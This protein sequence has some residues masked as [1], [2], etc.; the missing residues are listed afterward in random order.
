[1]KKDYLKRLLWIAVPIMV[2]NLIA[3]LQM[4]IDRIFL[5]RLDAG[6]MTVLGNVTSPMWTTMSFCFSIVT[7]ASILI[8]QGVG[9]G[10]HDKSEEY[11]SSLI[12]YNNIIPFLL[13]L[14]WTFCSGYVF[15]F[16]GVDEAFV[17]FCLEYTRF[18]A[19][20]F[21]ITGI[22]AS[23]NVILQTSNYTK[24]L[25]VY[26]VVRSGLNILLDWILIF[27]R[28]GLPAMGIKGAA[29]ATTLA[30]YTG[31]IFVFIVI[32]NSKKLPTRPSFKS[33]LKAKFPSYLKGVRLGINTAFEDF[34][35][36]FGNL[37]LIRILN[38]IDP[39][40]AGIYSIVFS[41]EILV[42]V[43]IGSIGNGTMTLTSE[44]TGKKDLK[45]YK[46]VCGIAYSIC[47]AVAIVMLVLF[48][49]IP[50]QIIAIFT[51][52]QSIIATSSIYLAFIGINLFAKSANI[53]VGNSIRGSGNTQWM[54]YTQIFG[55]V[56]V[57]AIA[58]LFVY[59]FHLG[60]AGVFLAV[61]VDEA[62]R[63]LINFAKFIYIT[64]HFAK[65]L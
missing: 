53:I 38:T 29:I 35:W 31:A 60:I 16:M 17:P 5:G 23:F 4:I 11:A 27:G 39:M 9:A 64:K 21:L 56:F 26:G 49:T 15:Q 20:V 41:V 48:L 62:V 54:F 12:K 3:Q 63:G 22:G 30:E 45:Q 50:S 55:T 57:V 36:N 1:M 18:Y 19:P 58:A 59:V 40:A 34:T 46:G 44:A 10:N 61:I 24:P 42:V 25:V 65:E 33:V 2:S 51:T 28:F 6:N 32:I 8:S 14:F 13:F 37:M 7:G 43:I 47:A 52:D